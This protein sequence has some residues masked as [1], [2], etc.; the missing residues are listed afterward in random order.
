MLKLIKYELKKQASKSL[1][2]FGILF[3]LF[4]F[5]DNVLQFK[6]GGSKPDL[7]AGNFGLSLL[8]TQFYLIFLACTYISS[9]FH[10]GTSK[11]IFTGVFSRIEIVNIKTISIMLIS[12]ALGGINW[13]IGLIL[14]VV[15]YDGVTI[16]SA[17]NDLL[18][19][20]VIYFLYFIGVL[21]FSLFVSSISLSRII[22]ILFGYGTFIF[23]GEIAVQI[24]N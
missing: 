6:Y 17:L 10:M 9:E 2:I 22:T 18:M 7:V 13:T 1:I 15:L 20:I 11:S 12:L 16:T 8:L 24:T 5:L 21:A 19:V 3:I 4:T 14:E 23:I